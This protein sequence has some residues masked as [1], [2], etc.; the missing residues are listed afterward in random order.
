MVRGTPLFHGSRTDPLPRRAGVLRL[1]EALAGTPNS[2]GRLRRAA[3][4]DLAEATP[5]GAT[6]CTLIVD[7]TF[8]VDDEA[9]WKTNGYGGIGGGEALLTETAGN[10]TLIA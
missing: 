6:G 9:H 4:E 10:R 8:D 2:H 3:R 7:D 5:D 1:L